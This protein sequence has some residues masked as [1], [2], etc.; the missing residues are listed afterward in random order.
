MAKGIKHINNYYSPNNL[1]NKIIDGLNKIGTDLSKV[2]LEDLQPVDEFH[3]RGDAATKELIKLSGFTP[4]MH[5]LDVG[6][7]IGGSTRR[8]AHEAG[9]TVTGID[10]SNEYI[11]TAERLTQ[12]LNMQEQVKFHACSALEACQP[13]PNTGDKACVLQA[14]S[15]CCD[16]GFCINND[17]WDGR[18]ISKSF[19]KIRIE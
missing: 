14:I 18:K 10:L 12:L 4:D 13:N 19:R 17:N 7:G 2:K 15:I 16:Q 1:Y 8:L 6:C 3:I 11:D 5:I 9:C